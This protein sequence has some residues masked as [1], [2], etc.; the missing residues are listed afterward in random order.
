MGLSMGTTT[1]PEGLFRVCRHGR[2]AAEGYSEEMSRTLI[3]LAP[4]RD[5]PDF[6]RLWIGSAV[7]SLGASIAAMTVS[8]QIF[9]LTHSS[10]AVGGVGLVSLVP[11]MLGGLCGG[12]V[13]DR[14]DR[15]TVALAA[16]SC[17]WII[18]GLI[19]V[20]AWAELNSVMVLY[21]LIAAQ[22]FTMPINQAA[23]GAIYPN[24]LPAEVLPKANALN[25]AVFT[26]GMM[27]GPVIGGVMISTLGY[28]WAYTVEVAVFSIGLWALYR[29]PPLPPQG[30]DAASAAR[31]LRSLR[32][33]LG[34]VSRSQVL[35]GS[36][37][38][39]I[40][41]M[42]FT[43][44][45]ALLPA[46]A[47]IFSADHET[48]AGFL[49]GGAA[50]G[51]FLGMLL[52]GRFTRVTH[53]GRALLRTYLGV[54][55]GAILAG[56]GAWATAVFAPGP[57]TPAAW[58]G[59]A[60]CLVGLMLNGASDSIGMIYRSSILQAAV[61]DRLR[62]RLQGVF[63]VVVSGGPRVGQG[64]LGAGAQLIGPGAA[65]AAGGAACAVGTLSIGRA[66]P[67]LAAYRAGE[68]ADGA[69]DGDERP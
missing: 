40:A 67:A 13:A 44:P 69:A 63:I 54:A 26:L 66:L 59:F 61:P 32:E 5:H 49:S 9:S 56:G 46:M 20:Q 24:I 64:L 58:I 22:S 36:F 11:V 15:R 30:D 57:D 35:A 38:V 55:A 7:S 45:L 27:L 34:F 52:S 3:D 53:Q 10:L 43:F 28:E 12:V 37:L 21:A 33:G 50:F 47:L 6:R 14:C 8:L 2:S 23:R 48:V 42:I 25:G 31:G 41:A 68:R 62:G 51:A 65:L 29:L 1:V 16:S 18:A 39:D 19:A 4:L 60:V 17:L